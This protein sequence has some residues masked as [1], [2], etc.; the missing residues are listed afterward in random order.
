[1]AFL[2][3]CISGLSCWVLSCCGEVTKSLRGSGEGSVEG[4]DKTCILKGVSNLNIK[5]KNQTVSQKKRGRK[6]KG[7][8]KETEE[9]DWMLLLIQLGP[10]MGALLFK[11][12]NDRW[13]LEIPCCQ[14]VR[15]T[16]FVFV[17]GS[18]SYAQVVELVKAVHHIWW[19]SGDGHH[20]GK[21]RS[22][23]RVW[24]GRL[25]SFRKGRL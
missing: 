14:Q 25:I 24:G 13:Q 22:N 16:D 5:K 9:L 4:E 18:T 2:S 7:L 19:V 12:V 6:R 23:D 1:M 15:R 17:H 20:C 8:L 10:V 11:S 3:Y 21:A